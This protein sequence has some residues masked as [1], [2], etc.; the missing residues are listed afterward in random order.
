MHHFFVDKGQITETEIQIVGTDVR[1]IR[2]VLRMQPGEDLEVGDGQG[3]EYYCR[4]REINEEAVVAEILYRQQSEAE[5]PSRI[6]LFQG[7]P[8]GD[9]LELIIQKAIELGAAEIIPVDMKRS[10]AK[11]DAK[12]A[13][14]KQERWN[15]IAQSAAKQSKRGVIPQVT[16]PMS[17][18]EALV[19]ARQADILLVPYEGA[20]NMEETRKIISEIKPGQSV[21][22][23]IG[24]EGGFDREEVE[25]LKEQNGKIVTLGRRI[26][27]TETAG[28]AVLSILVYHLER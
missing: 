21:A 20:E 23:W 6:F 15:G 24:P 8:K 19:Y 10:V 17:F 16:K 1:H 25:A 7:L 9:K 26:L 3:S 5:L 13:G 18:R 4:I 27:R 11:V 2:N 14:K 22:V 28:L 12:K